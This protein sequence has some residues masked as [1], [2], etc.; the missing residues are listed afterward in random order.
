MSRIISIKGFQTKSFVSCVVI[1]LTVQTL[2]RHPKK[3]DAR[4]R[5]SRRR[6]NQRKNDEEG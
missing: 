2:H 6:R 3:N 4:G 1:R 5:R